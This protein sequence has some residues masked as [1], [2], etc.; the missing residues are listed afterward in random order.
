[1]SYLHL[2]MNLNISPIILRQIKSVY[3]RIV[4]T[5]IHLHGHDLPQRLLV[6]QMQKR[7]VHMKQKNQ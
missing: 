2:L 3:G 7:H 1:M 5:G 6:L 4:V